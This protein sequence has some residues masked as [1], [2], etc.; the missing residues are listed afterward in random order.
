MVA[1]APETL[2]IADDHDEAIYDR[3]IFPRIARPLC[4]E[5]HR[6][7]HSLS[8]LRNRRL[9][10]AVREISLNGM[11]ALSDHPMHAGEHISA[12]FPPHDGRPAFFAFGRVIRCEPSATGYRVAVE[13][14]PLPA[15]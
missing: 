7:D 9:Q 6:L 4:V 5:A 3:R 1:L 12:T 15:A 8:A 14:D 2:R 11:S 10:L 13:F